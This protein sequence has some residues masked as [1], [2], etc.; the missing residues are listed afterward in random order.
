[1][2][3]I[4]HSGVR[5]GN[6]IER[7]GWASSVLPPNGKQRSAPGPSGTFIA[8]IRPRCTS[9]T[10]T[11]ATWRRRRGRAKGARS[12][13]GKGCS[14]PTKGTVTFAVGVADLAHWP[15]HASRAAQGSTDA[16]SCA[17][18]G[19]RPTAQTYLGIEVDAVSWLP[20]VKPVSGRDPVVLGR[21]GG[22]AAAGTT[23]VQAVTTQVSV[24][25]VTVIRSYSP[26]PPGR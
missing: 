5:C 22:E 14:A 21:D 16:F 18:A 2:L 24:T 3:V 7:I 13:T 17:I 20:A 10:D 25:A 23:Y 19:V 1:M 4:D 15:Q 8:R 12:L 9:Q 26:R 6:F 11:A